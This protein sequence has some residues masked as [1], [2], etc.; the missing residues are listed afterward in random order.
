MLKEFARN[1]GRAA[2]APSSKHA[3]AAT[4]PA[5]EA[6]PPLSAP[7][8][9]RFVVCLP[10]P[11]PAD[12]THQVSIPKFQNDAAFVVPVFGET[13]LHIYV[14]RIRR[15]VHSI[16]LDARDVPAGTS[17]SDPQPIWRAPSILSL[18]F[19]GLFPAI[20]CGYRFEA[21]PRPYHHHL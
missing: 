19:H 16:F 21:L 1:S 13:D 18:S 3:P 17:V 2:S 14:I 8:T 10:G 11:S 5:S 15:R 6:N 4:P 20:A 9:R 12:S 7:K